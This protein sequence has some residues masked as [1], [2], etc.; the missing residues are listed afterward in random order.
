[1]VTGSKSAL[2]KNQYHLLPRVFS[3][4]SD[5]SLQWQPKSKSVLALHYG[6]YPDTKENVDI[7]SV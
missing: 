1:M 7:S 6:E 2:E 3:S 4:L 5:P